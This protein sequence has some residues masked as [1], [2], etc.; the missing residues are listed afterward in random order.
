[1]LLSPYTNSHETIS[2][3]P[4]ISNIPEASEMPSTYHG[5]RF[6]AQEVRIHILGSAFRNPQTDKNRGHKVGHE[7]SH[8]DG[9]NR[10]EAPPTDQ[11]QLDSQESG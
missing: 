6:A 4:E 10:H 5:K 11:L 7:H 9:M 2:I 3:V 8:I 1:M